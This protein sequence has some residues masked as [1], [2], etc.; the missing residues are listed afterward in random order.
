[1]RN[2]LQRSPVSLKI[3]SAALKRKANFEF[4]FLI[5]CYAIVKNVPPN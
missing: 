1:M 4:D 3:V 5:K 2:Y